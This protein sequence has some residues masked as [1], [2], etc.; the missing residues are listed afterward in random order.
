[1]I[2]VPKHLAEELSAMLNAAEDVELVV[3]KYAYTFEVSYTRDLWRF[4]QLLDEN[5]VRDFEIERGQTTLG[6]NRW[7]IRY[8]HDEELGMEVWT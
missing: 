3:V 6:G 7:S 5:S 1:M 4:I 8:N 2:V